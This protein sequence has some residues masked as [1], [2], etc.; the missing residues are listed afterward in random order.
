MRPLK[1]PQDLIFLDT[2]DQNFK[3]PLPWKSPVS[4]STISY[5]LKPALVDMGIPDLMKIQHAY[6]NEHSGDAIG[7]ILL[8]NAI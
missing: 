7:F 6:S 2:A 1:L 4:Q 5:L 3:I 8:V